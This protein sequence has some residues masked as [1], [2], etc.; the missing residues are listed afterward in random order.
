MTRGHWHTRRGW[1]LPAAAV[2]F[3]FA[4][5]WLR[6]PPWLLH[7]SSGLGRVETG[8]DGAPARW[9]G[10]HASFFVAADAGEVRLRLRA[11]FSPPGGR[12]VTVSIALDDV[13]VE[14]MVLIDHA[15]REA[16]FRMPHPA[17]RR[18]RRIDVRADWSGE[19]GRA[20]LLAAPASGGAR[21][22]T[23]TFSGSH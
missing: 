10:P 13:P 3:V 19:D 20:V 7:Y 14:R 21:T 23:L 6:D 5:A 22:G 1:G 16:V 17:N 4:L 15:W 8:P 18:V 9:A 12:A 11:P 2:V